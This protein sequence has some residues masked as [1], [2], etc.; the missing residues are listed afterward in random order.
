MRSY[1]LLERLEIDQ[2]WR[3]GRVIPGHSP[4]QW[5]LDSYG[6]LIQ[7]GDYGDTTSQYG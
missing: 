6:S 7:Y 5:R 1:S 3:K 2:V 4:T